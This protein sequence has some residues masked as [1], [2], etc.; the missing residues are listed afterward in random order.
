MENFSAW[1]SKNIKDSK[2]VC[3]ILSKLPVWTSK[4]APYHAS[5]RRRW[6]A[7]GSRRL[8]RWMQ[9]FINH[10]AKLIWS[11]DIS[12]RKGKLINPL[13]VHPTGKQGVPLDTTDI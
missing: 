7:L 3:T 6:M 12:S 10:T 1:F 13:K 9:A 11:F 4:P 5:P 2:I 8:S